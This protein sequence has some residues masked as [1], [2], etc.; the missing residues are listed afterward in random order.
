MRSALLSL[1]WTVLLVWAVLTLAG[2][3]P[4]VAYV[5]RTRDVCYSQYETH[6]PWEYEFGFWRP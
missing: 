6:I 5:E 3:A 2:P 1:V 4:E